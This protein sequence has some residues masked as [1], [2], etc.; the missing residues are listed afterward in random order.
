V[1]S[2]YLNISEIPYLDMCKLILYTEM[3]HDLGLFYH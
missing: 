2:A 1:L 3:A